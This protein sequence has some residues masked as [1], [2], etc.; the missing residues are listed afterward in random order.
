MGSLLGLLGLGLGLVLPPLDGVLHRRLELLLGVR[1]QV[2]H[3]LPAGGTDT[4]ENTYD[5]PTAFS[6]GVMVE[7]NRGHLQGGG[8]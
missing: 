2:P 7:G 5:P 3:H 6:G 8:I 4:S 1:L